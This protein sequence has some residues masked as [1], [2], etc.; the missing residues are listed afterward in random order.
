MTDSAAWTAFYIALSGKVRTVVPVA[1][2]HLTPECIMDDY[3]SIGGATQAEVSVN[4]VRSAAP[5]LSFIVGVVAA[6]ALLVVS[7]GQSSVRHDTL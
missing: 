6:A 7:L 3:S 2:A 1:Q 5:H 4:E